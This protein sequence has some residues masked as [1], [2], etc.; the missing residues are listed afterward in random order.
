MR[1]TVINERQI[2]AIKY[3]TLMS[4]DA[5][6]ETKRIVFAL[7]EASHYFTRSVY[8][9]FDSEIASTGIHNMNSSGCSTHLSEVLEI[10]GTNF[11]FSCA[12]G[13]LAKKGFISS[14]RPGEKHTCTIWLSN[15]SYDPKAMEL[16][17]DRINSVELKDHLYG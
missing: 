1:K 16:D 8:Y 6:E 5:G 17:Q 9:T 10:A 15:I 11:F 14:N 3:L 2:N 4:K 12:Y 13:F 7:L